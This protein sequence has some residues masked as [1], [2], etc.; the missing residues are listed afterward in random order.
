MARAGF[1]RCKTRLAIAAA[2]AA[3][4]PVRASVAGTDNWIGGSSDWNTPT[5]WDSGVVPGQNDAVNIINTDGTSPTITYDYPGP[6]V[7]L[8]PLVVNGIGGTETFQMSTAGLVLSTGGESIG[9]SNSSNSTLAAIGVV[10]ESGGT[11]YSDSIYLGYYGL[12][13]GTFFLGGPSLLSI[14]GSLIVGSMGEGVFNQTGG[15]DQISGGN[16]LILG[17]FRGSTGTYNLTATGTISVSGALTSSGVEYIGF[18]GMGILNQFGGANLIVGDEVVGAFGN[19]ICNQSGGKTTISGQLYLGLS[20]L[21]TATY[22]LSGKGALSAQNEYIGYTGTDEGRRTPSYATGT[23]IQNGGTNSIPRNGSLYIGYTG[24]FIGV[25][26]NYLLDGNGTLNSLGE[27]YVGYSRQSTGT[28]T[29]SG[30]LNLI[31]PTASIGDLFVGYYAGSNGS[32]NLSGSG[33]LLTI[34]AGQY[35]GYSGAGNFNQSGGTFRFDQQQLIIGFNTGS[36]G[37]Y[38]LSG[39]GTLTAN[40]DESVAVNGAGSFIQSGGLNN[41]GGGLYLGR[42]TGS[43]G[44]YTL[45]GTGVLLVSGGEYV[46]SSSLGMFSQN[47]GT[48][49]IKSSGYLAIQSG[50]FYSLSGGSLLAPSLSISSTGSFTQSGGTAIFSNLTGS[51]TA[52]LTGGIFNLALGGSPSQLGTFNIS[53]SGLLDLQIGGHNQGVDY[54]LLNIANSSSLGGT[55]EVDLV[56]GFIPQIGDQFTVM[57]D[58]TPFVGTFDNLTSNDGL[59]TYSVDYG[60]NHNLVEIAVTSV[61]EP[62]VATLLAMGAI[63]MCCRRK[64]FKHLHKHISEI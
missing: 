37:T 58:A 32:Y 34:D 22:I 18:A 43:T 11:I 25:T 30:G 1:R 39:T 24:A 49:K 51:G 17:D 4:W 5:N 19:G 36:A 8:G 38:L 41:I 46:G 57:T 21:A 53:G 26:G 9:R 12:D 16:T 50:S 2:V 62:G 29:Q 10:N 6:L 27:E 63:A 55:L 31:D 64:R 7:T 47:G 52:T 45:T 15:T 54:D 42:G 61:P 35:I 40:G 44:T 20:T 14:Y 60:A 23:F 13:Q 33:L 3:L 48:N 59:F 28:F 56:N